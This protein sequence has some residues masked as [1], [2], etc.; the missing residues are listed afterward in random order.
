MSANNHGGGRV[1]AFVDA[2]TKN[3]FF[4]V[5]SKR[6]AHKKSFFNCWTNKVWVPPTLGFRRLNF[7]KIWKWLRSFRTQ[8]IKIAGGHNDHFAGLRDLIR[9]EL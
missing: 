5:L 3:A 9:P 7:G 6:N 2:S 1:K 8:N 4:Y